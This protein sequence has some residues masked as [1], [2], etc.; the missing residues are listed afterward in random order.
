MKIIISGTPGTGKTEVSR[1][2]SD[3]LG[4]KLVRINEFAKEKDIIVGT[5]KDRKSEIIDENKLQKLSKDIPDN[6]VIEGH[7]AHYC[8]ADIAIILRTDPSVLEKRLK[9]RRWNQKKIRENIESE[10]LDIILQESAA[11]NKN[12]YEIDTTIKTAKDAAEEIIGMLKSDKS[13]K[14]H[15]P[16]HISWEKYML[17][18]SLQA[19]NEYKDHNLFKS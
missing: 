17:D 19:K 2:L 8:K 16:G 1:I 15:L 7:L 11:L 18:L 5:D 12:T 10:I 3:M 9:R 6:T 13:K 14:A 4:Y